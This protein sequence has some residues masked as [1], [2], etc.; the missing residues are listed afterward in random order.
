MI[1]QIIKT[2]ITTDCMPTERPLII[3]VA[4]PVCPASA[5]SLI[6]FPAV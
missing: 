1:K 5:I 4:E 2:G 3:T 6:G